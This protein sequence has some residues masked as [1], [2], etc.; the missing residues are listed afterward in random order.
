MDEIRLVIDITEGKLS[1]LLNDKASQLEMIA[2]LQFYQR[3]LFDFTHPYHFLH[4]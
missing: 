2:H 3:S 1:H 4:N